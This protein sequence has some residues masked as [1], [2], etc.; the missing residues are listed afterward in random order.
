MLET[1]IYIGK[2]KQYLTPVIVDRLFEPDIAYKFIV[3]K[4]LF[5][6]TQSKLF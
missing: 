1:E 3:T 2:A 5:G 6:S 4:V